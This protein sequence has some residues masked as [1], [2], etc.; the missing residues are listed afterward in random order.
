MMQDAV[1]ELAEIDTSL[2]KTMEL[3][4]DPFIG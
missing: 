4:V 1:R 3:P 2:L